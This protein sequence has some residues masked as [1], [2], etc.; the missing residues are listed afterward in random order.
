MHSGTTNGNRAKTQRRANNVPLRGQRGDKCS[1]PNRKGLAA[2]AN[3]FCQPR[4][5]SP[6][7]KLQS[8]GKSGFSISARYKKAEKIFPSTPGSGSHRPAHKKILSR[9]ENT[10]RILKWKFKLEAFDITYRPRTLIRGQI[11]ADSIAEKPEEVG[12]SAE[13][14]TTETIPE[15]W[16]LFTD[17]SSCL[18]GSG[19]G[20][21][22]TSP[23]GEEFTYALRFEFNASNN[24]AE[25]E[26][27]IAGLRISEQ[28]NV[29]NLIAKVDSRLV[30]NQ[31]KGMYE[32]KEQSMTQYLEKAKA[33]I[34]NFKKFSIKQGSRSEN[35]KADALSKITS[36]SFAHLTKQVLVKTLQKNQ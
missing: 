23:E 2:D 18:E 34:D 10:E 3:L 14:Q 11:L 26:A 4:L 6:G 12:P 16:T 1:P 29:K 27:L 32:A 15:P 33:L 7:D 35:K 22:L 25:Y 19:A 31:I 21:I 36:T 5:A 24:E 17:G 28:M 20:L 9:P 30:A 8:N 13:V